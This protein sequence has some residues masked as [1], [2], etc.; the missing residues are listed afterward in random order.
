MNRVIHSIA[1]ML[2]S[3]LLVACGTDSSSG[4]AAGDPSVTSTKGVT[5]S[6]SS[7]TGSKS[8]FSLRLTDAPVD[9]ATAVVMHFVAV[10]L[11][12]TNGG[13]TRV[14]FLNP[15][16]IDLLKLQGIATA[17]LLINIEAP[18]SDYNEIRLFVDDL[19]MANYIVIG[20]I[21][22]ELKI[23]SGS[24]SGLKVKGDF[25]ISKSRSASLIIDFD[26]RQ[27]IKTAGN[28][29]NGNGNS[30][31]GNGNSGNGNGSSGNGNGNSGN[32]NGNSG[33][34][35][36]H[37]V[38]RL[39]SMENV[40]HISG[41]V[42]PADLMTGCSDGNVDTFNAVYVFNGHVT[43]GDI[44]SDTEPFTTTRIDYDNDSMSYIYE[45]AFLP[46]GDYT[47]AFTCNADLDDPDKNDKLVFFNY[48]NVTVVVNDIVFL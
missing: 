30:G 20:G 29:G 40:G 10:E 13:W 38:L 21:S 44:G 47:I 36:F 16:M 3:S 39:A 11:R 6:S 37:P 42:N 15:K 41:T 46:K 25:T 9:N 48:K 23:P 5:V 33:S 34:Y 24:T 22:E 17:D 4:S 1:I 12:A 8:S 35:V 26:L 19:P 27:S 14:T 28:S 18:A 7:G 31:N 32:G 43:P 2:L 45:A